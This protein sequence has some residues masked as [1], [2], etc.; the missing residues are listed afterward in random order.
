MSCNLMQTGK[1]RAKQTLGE[2]EADF[3]DALRVRL[4]RATIVLNRQL[5]TTGILTQPY[6][7][8]V[9]L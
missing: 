3:L 8:V 2:K 7:A 6:L 9:L 4:Y 1:P 5:T